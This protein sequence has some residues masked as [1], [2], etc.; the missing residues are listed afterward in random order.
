MCG[1][2]PAEKVTRVER[3]PLFSIRNILE[4]WISGR[5]M[6]LQG[7]RCSQDLQ[8]RRSVHYFV[9]LIEMTFT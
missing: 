4:R 6:T 3:I 1:S 7:N 5:N 2:M 9:N 8:L